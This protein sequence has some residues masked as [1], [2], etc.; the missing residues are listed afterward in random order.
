MIGLR[1]IAVAAF[2]LTAGHAVAGDVDT[3]RGA[4][5]GFDFGRY[6]EGACVDHAVPGWSGYP[7]RLCTYSVRGASR[8]AQVVLLDADDAQLSRWIASAC[9]AARTNDLIFCARKLAR[10]IRDQSGAQF[11]VAGIVLEDMDGDG[12]PNQ[13]AFRD[14]VT[15]VVPG[16]TNGKAGPPTP[17]ETEAG[18]TAAPTAARKFARI[19]G[20]TREQF[21]SY[22]GAGDVAGLAWLAA[23][24]TAYQAAW[25][26][27]DNDLVS[28]FAVVNR[29]SLSR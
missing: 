14:G 27:D 10:Q 8:P 9:R 24:R 26:A 6:M 17:A 11:P 21:T 29:R 15:A 28:A 13:F 20:T 18:L 7:T 3:V 12:V 22:R 2:F 25:R 1:T 16:V 23:V 5:R 19:A 4:L